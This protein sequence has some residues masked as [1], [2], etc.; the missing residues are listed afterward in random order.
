MWGQSH[1]VVDLEIWSRLVAGSES[2]L[3]GSVLLGCGVGRTVL[4]NEA[5]VMA[6]RKCLVHVGY[7]KVMAVGC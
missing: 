6:A 3:G 7:S 5:L 4:W 1:L 2:L